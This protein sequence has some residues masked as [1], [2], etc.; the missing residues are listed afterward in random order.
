MNNGAVST[1]TPHTIPSKIITIERFIL[2]QQ[3]RCSD[4]SRALTGLLY[5]LA[6]SAKLIASQTTL[7]GLAD[8]LG[9]TGTVNVQGEDVQQLDQFAERTIHRINDHTGRLAVMASEEQP[10]IIPIPEQY[11]RAPFFIGNRE[12]VEKVEELQRQSIQSNIR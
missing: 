3:E 8:I 6:L 9:S 5:D 1:A 11:Q 4:D 2:E 10:F 12:L 7:A